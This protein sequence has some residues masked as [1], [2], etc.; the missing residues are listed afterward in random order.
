MNPQIIFTTKLQDLP[1][2]SRIYIKA[3]E[4]KVFGYAII[5]NDQLGTGKIKLLE[6]YIYEPY[7]RFGHGK[8]IIDKVLQVE[9]KSP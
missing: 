6:I 3:I 8:S 4:N 1:K 5:C 7:Q 2:D 9:I